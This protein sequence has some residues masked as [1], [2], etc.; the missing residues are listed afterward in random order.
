MT[1]ATLDT[2]SRPTPGRAAAARAAFTAWRHKARTAAGR[3]ATNV[4][5]RVTDLRSAALIVG[6]FGFVDAAA[7]SIG[8]VLGLGATGVSLWLLEWLSD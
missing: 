2:H 8:T 3:T 6:G 7:Y 4:A 5:G 1:T